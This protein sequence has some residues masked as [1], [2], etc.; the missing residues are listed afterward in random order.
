MIKMEFIFKNN[1]NYLSKFYSNRGFYMAISP[2]PFVG[3]IPCQL[4]QE[5][6][7]I[8]GTVLPLKKLFDIR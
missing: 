7:K 6:E 5:K 2:V 3:L 1:E 4:L 8:N